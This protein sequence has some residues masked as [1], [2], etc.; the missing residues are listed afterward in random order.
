N[1]LGTGKLRGIAAFDRW[2]RY[3][4]NVKIRANKDMEE[5]AGGVE[6]PF[7]IRNMIAAQSRI[8]EKALQYGAISK[9]AM[10]ICYFQ[11]LFV[12]AI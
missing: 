10:M 5:Y 9:S 8:P 4:R 11:N 2:W 7:V 3:I 1:E 6:I 12:G